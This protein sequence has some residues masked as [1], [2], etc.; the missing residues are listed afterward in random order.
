MFD[1]KEQT[2]ESFTNS[3]STSKPKNME[4]FELHF[5]TSDF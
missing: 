4:D 5:E 3:E 1:L 2:S